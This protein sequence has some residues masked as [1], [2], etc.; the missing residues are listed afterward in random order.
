MTKSTILKLSGAALAVIGIGAAVVFRQDIGDSWHAH[1]KN[2]LALELIKQ[3]QWTDALRAA[4]E[5]TDLRPGS[6]DYQLTYTQV[7]RAFLKAAKPKLAL[8]DPVAFLT[9]VNKMTT[10][11]GPALDD[12]GETQLQSWCTEREAPALEEAGAPFDADMDALGKIFKGR[13]SF[14]VDLFSPGNQSKARGLLTAWQNF[15]AAETAWKTNN[16]DEVAARLE[17]IPA[18]FRKAVYDSFQKRLDGVRKEIKERWDAAN[19]LV[20][21]NDYLGAKAI[22]TELQRHEAWTPGLQSARLAM[23]SGGEGFFTQ[24]MVEANMAKQYHDAG[25]W[26]FK[27]L[28]L[29]GQNTQGI[30]FDDVFKGGTTAD[31]LNQLASLGLHPGPAQERKNFTDALLVAA[32]L[33]NLTDPDAAHQFLGATYLDWATKEVQRGRFG[34]AC[35]LSLLA[36]KHGNPAASEVFDKAHAGVMN[37]LTVIIAA[38]PPANQISS[39]DKDFSDDLYS[40]AVNA[41]H[42][43]LLPWMKF[44]DA[45]QPAA[46]TASNGVFRVK[47]KAGINKFSPD[48]QRKIRQVSREFPVKVIVD[49]PAIPEAQQQ[50]EQAQ[51]DLTA[52]QRKYQSDKQSAQLAGQATSMVANQLFGGLGGMV[53]GGLAG[54]AVAN[55]VSTAGV[56]SANRALT[57]AQDALANMPRQVEQTQSKLFTWNETDHTTTYH[58]TF[59]IGLGVTD[60]TPWSQPFSASVTHKT[61]ERRGIDQVNLAPL[62]REQPDLQKIESILAADLKNQIHAFSGNNALAGIKTSL[63]KYCAGEGAGTNPEAGLDTQLSAEF[64]WWDSPLRDYKTLATPALLGKFGDV[65]NAPAK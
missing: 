53:A 63:Q 55:S 47:I 37:Q 5:A 38:Q 35:Y 34:N 24:K 26:L 51:A 56:D 19:N 21:K 16:A 15:D 11:L 54:G 9:E 8:L 44:E 36:T 17:K 18:D 39:A 52:A 1:Q 22:F 6:A 25:D 50:V 13:E 64:L 49:N 7:R 30:N 20:L 29:Q 45:G 65:V 31:F 32:N 23:Q 27:L 57:S 10:E 4:H 42:E 2:Q 41:M 43:S 14:F 33:D 48:Y 60:S 28:T 59:Q 3:E 58:A 12:D 40:A 61:T 46:A 62:D